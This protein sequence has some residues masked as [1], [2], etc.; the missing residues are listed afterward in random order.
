MTKLKYHAVMYGKRW[1]VEK[2][3]GP[4]LVVVVRVCRSAGDALRAAAELEGLTDGQYLAA[5]L[6]ETGPLLAAA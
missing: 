3:S 1:A 2:A 6:D 4:G 5:L